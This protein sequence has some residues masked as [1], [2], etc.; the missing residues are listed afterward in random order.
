MADRVCVGAIAGAFGVKGEARIK[1]FTG[2]PG[3]I[4]EYGPLESEDGKRSFEIKITRRLKGG[5]A[6]RLS[7]VNT[8][9][10]AEALK[11]ARLYVPRARLPEPEEDEF[12]YADLIGLFIEDP[13]GARIGRIKAVQD[14]GAGDMLEY[15][16]E[17]GGESRYLPFT[18]EVVPSVD[19]A[20][21]KVIA[22]LPKEIEQE[23]GEEDSPT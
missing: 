13:E 15:V 1:S 8:R 4:S 16:P 10:E 22:L 3:A 18:R 11:S 20:A 7:G 12:Y 23:A 19:I 2:D 6:A 21:G 17:G 5:F 9:E 14:F